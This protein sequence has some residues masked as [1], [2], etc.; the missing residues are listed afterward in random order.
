[1]D[2]RS[3]FFSFRGRINRGK[4]WLAVLVFF[5]VDI[6]LILAGLVAGDSAVFQALGELINVAAF[7]AGLAV[8]TKRLHDRDKS[9]WW[10]A[11]YYLG[12]GLFAVVALFIF[13][14]SA[15]A[16]GMALQWSFLLLRLCILGGIGL[17]V[18]GL[19][20]LGF[21]RGSTGYN[22]YGPNPLRSRRVPA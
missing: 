8:A 18:W 16:V 13:W 17:A 9:A 20:E 22:R 2:W 1:M 12:P 19:V 3:L 4:F 15:G 21:R 5:I 14:V 6:V 7:A 11:L 10:V